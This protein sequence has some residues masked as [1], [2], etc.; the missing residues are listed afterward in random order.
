M[1]AQDG[2]ELDALVAAVARQFAGLFRGKPVQPDLEQPPL[3]WDP[4]NQLPDLLWPRRHLAL[5]G[6]E[7]TQSI[8]YNG[9]VGVSYGD[10]NSIPLV[11]L[12]P[13]VVRAYPYV[14]PGVAEPDTLTGARVTGELVLSV[15][16]RIVYRTGPTRADG[17]RLGAR[18]ELSRDLWDSELTVPVGGPGALAVHIVHVNSSLNFFVP[19]WY[20][21]TGHFYLSVRLWR[22]GSDGVSSAPQD[23]VATGRYIDFI[24]VRP[25]RVAVVRVNWTDSAGKVTSPTDAIML[26]TMRTAERML[27]FPYFETTILGTSTNS[28]AAFAS[29]ATGGGCNTAWT[30]LLADLAVTRIFTALFQLGD[31]VFAFVPSAAIPAAAGSYNTGCGLAEG[32]GA[33]FAGGDTSFAYDFIFAHEMGHVFT[34]NHV[35][36]P[37]DSSDDPNYPN[38]GGSKTS[39]GEVGIDPGT[40][41]PTLFGPSDTSDIMSYKPK[42]WISPYTYLKIL[43]ARDNHQ[44]APADPRRVR[45]LL[46]LAVRVHRPVGDENRIEIRK[47]YRIEAA[48]MVSRPSDGAISPLSVDLLDAHRRIIATHH[49]LYTRAQATCG[50]CGGGVAVPLNREPFYDLHEAI[51][52]PSEEVAAISLHDGR[53]PFATFEVGEPP[54]VE[55]SGPERRDQFLVLRVHAHHPRARPSIVVLFSGDDR[56]TWQPVA[57]DPPDGEVLVESERLPGGERC[58][59]RAIATAEFRSASADSSQFE[60]QRS[61]RRLYLRLPDPQ[62]PIAPGAVPLGAMIDCRGLGVVRSDEIR[63][64]SDLD[65]DLGLGYELVAQ[66]RDGRHLITVTAPDGRGGSLAE[67]GIIIVGGRPA[68]VV[69]Q[70]EF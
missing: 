5:A 22:A 33:A 65:G 51:E 43:N 35:A 63:W 55:L 25:P 29:A 1:N 50:C 61:R 67:R 4:Q 37:G 15:G 13:L 41:P 48:G 47:A 24:D 57:F 53:E 7:L 26:S 40:T 23:R 2:P 68:G 59:F 69:S 16:D 12:K 42:Q 10:D 70:A 62:C 60:L 34:C 17:A 14:Q 36:V 54:Q 66:L 45:S 46:I 18:N 56:A 30:G 39:I 58:F 28:S 49:C 64:N 3:P 44:T 9:A 27:P 31:I 11:A 52:W 21:R 19:A 38:Y 32:V 20:C 8:Q 6:L